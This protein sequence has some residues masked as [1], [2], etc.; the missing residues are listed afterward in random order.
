MIVW[1]AVVWGG[2]NSGFYN[3]VITLLPSDNLDI[4]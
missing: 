1:S 2:L 3:R 4:L